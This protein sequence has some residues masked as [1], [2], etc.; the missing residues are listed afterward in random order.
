MRLPGARQSEHHARRSRG[1][2]HRGAAAAATI[3]PRKQLGRYPTPQHGDRVLL[4]QRVDGHVRVTDRPI[5]RGQRS[6]VVAAG[7]SPSPSSPSC[8]CTMPRLPSVIATSRD[9]RDGIG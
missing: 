9:R 8:C 1:G 2:Y 3:G 4:A 6:Y 7:C 5:A